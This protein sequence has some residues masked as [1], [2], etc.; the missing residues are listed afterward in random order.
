MRALDLLQGPL[1]DPSLSAEMAADLR[2]IGDALER[3]GLAQH[4]VPDDL[5]GAD[6]ALS[7]EDQFETVV[8]R[9]P[10]HL[11]G[12]ARAARAGDPTA[13]AQLWGAIASLAADRVPEE[14]HA[15][16]LRAVGDLSQ[17]KTLAD[18]VRVLRAN[19]DAYASARTEGR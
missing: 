7:R 17:T 5:A 8:G 10:V 12:T 13:L 18:A 6:L 11:R 15:F 19:L 9:L 4:E 16:L 1:N 2:G 14:H 3:L